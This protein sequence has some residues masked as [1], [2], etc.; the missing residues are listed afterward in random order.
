MNDFMQYD[1][2][3]SKI[4]LACY[5]GKRMGTPI[6][7]N[8]P[9]HGLAFHTS[10]LKHYTF[11][12]GERITVKP[13]EMIYL[14]KYSDYEVS[15]VTEGDCFAINFDISEDI[16]FSPFKV[17]LKNTSAVLER[18]KRAENIWNKKSPGYILQCKAELYGIIYAMVKGYYSQYIP[19]EKYII[20]KP[21]VEYIHRTYT[22][23]LVNISE[24][25]NMCGIT[26]EYFRKL[27]KSFYG[28]SPL[29]YIND[30]KITRAKELLAS[31][32]YSV[33]EAALQ[34]GYTDMS[35]FSREFKKATGSSPKY[36]IL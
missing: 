21:A 1:F 27:F 2:N 34:S 25:S 12:S 5:V 17:N 3:I 9:S 36:Y 11:E 31:G 10:G 19:N 23:G 26:P 15:F 33:T 16:T 14:P 22:E 8:R 24:L 32:M 28:V 7:K 30:L 20:I 6:H 13:N 35:Y 29:K 18:F 4:V